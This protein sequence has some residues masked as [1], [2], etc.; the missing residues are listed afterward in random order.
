LLH[1]FEYPLSLPSEFNAVT[2]KYHVPTP[3]P[4]TVCLGVALFPT[5]AE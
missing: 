2:T 4:V 3:S 1:T 5:F